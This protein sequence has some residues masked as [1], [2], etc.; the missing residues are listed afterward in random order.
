M[1]RLAA[2][3]LLL[4]APLFAQTDPLPSWREGAAKS[5][6]LDFVAAAADPASQ[7]F[8][9]EPERVA[10]FDNDGTL[11]AEQPIYV[12]ATFIFDRAARLAAADPAWA[13]TPALQAAAAGDVAGVLSGGT[14]ALLEVVNAATTGMSVET[15]V[16]EVADW[17]ATARHPDTG[18][19][20]TQ[21]VYE[22]MLELLDLLR[23]NGFETYIVTG[24]GQ[25]FVRAFA[26]TSYG[27]PPQN[28]IGTVLETRFEIIDGVPEVM[29]A[30]GVAFIDDGAGKP[31]GIVRGIGRR[32]VFVAGNSDGDKEMLDWATAGPDP[33][34]GLLVH[35]TDADREW[36]YDRESAIGGLDAAPDAGW[37]VVDMAEDWTTVYPDR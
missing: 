8:V 12:Q 2:A 27:I 3:L 13:T 9:P 6:I 10:V 15:F 16:A 34:M 36:A 14:E 21:M 18:L 26:E 35:H 37:V 31:V 24:G 25:D 30:P 23:D 29:R 19:L 4:A 28:V 17:L 20:Y 11:W 5:A 22:P 7:G 32:P 33:R 1:L